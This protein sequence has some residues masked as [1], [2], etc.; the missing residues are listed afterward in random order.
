VDVFEGRIP[1][2]FSASSRKCGG[3]E[4]GENPS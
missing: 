4:C 2:S 3:R 1:P